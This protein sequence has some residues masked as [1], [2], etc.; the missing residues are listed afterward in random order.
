M[1]SNAIK[2]GISIKIL[3]IYLVCNCHISFI[4]PILAINTEN[5]KYKKMCF[6]DGV[7]TKYL[8]RYLAFLYHQN[9]T[10]YLSPYVRQRLGN[11]VVAKHPML[12][13]AGKQSRGRCPIQVP[14]MVDLRQGKGL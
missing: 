8:W 14:F 12:H 13:F 11:S 4:N 2:C 9:V 3:Y 7:P 1:R 5:L 10:K 6:Y